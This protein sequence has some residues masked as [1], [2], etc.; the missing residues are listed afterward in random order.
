MLIFYKSFKRLIKQRSLYQK[1]YN[2]N[3]H[4][5]EKYFEKIFHLLVNKRI[6]SQ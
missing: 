6:C 4:K 2:F 5:L 3:Q 1:E